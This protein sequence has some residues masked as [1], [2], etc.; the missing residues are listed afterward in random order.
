MGKE[1][2][3]LFFIFSNQPHVK[4]KLNTEVFINFISFK[5]STIDKIYYKNNVRF[6]A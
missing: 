4:E 2:K 1:E 5:V 3:S 6:I